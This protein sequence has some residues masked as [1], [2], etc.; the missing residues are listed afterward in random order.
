ML[1]T[2]A[3]VWKMLHCFKGIHLF[4]QNS[5]KSTKGQMYAKLTLANFY[6][7]IESQ[8]KW[9]AKEKHYLFLLL[10]FGFWPSVRKDHPTVCSSLPK[11][12]DLWRGN[13]NWQMGRVEKMPPRGKREMLVSTKE[14]VGQKQIFDRDT[15]G[16]VVGFD[17]L[18]NLYCLWKAPE[19]IMRKPRTPPTNR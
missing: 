13:C 9:L 5:F 17:L 11:N 14:R 7:T 15:G 1:E 2:N 16:L 4:S 10:L 3:F 12:Q 18:V 19:S 8:A 6:V